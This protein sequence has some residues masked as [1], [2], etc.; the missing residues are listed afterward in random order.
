MEKVK[1]TVMLSDEEILEI[2]PYLD[3]LRGKP[4]KNSGQGVSL[5]DSDIIYIFDRLTSNKSTV[6]PPLSYEALRGKFEQLNM[7]V[8]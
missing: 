1:T 6:L 8:L 5:D 3:V 7:I 4:Y 2:T